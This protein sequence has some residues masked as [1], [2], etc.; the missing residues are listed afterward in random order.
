MTVQRPILPSVV[1]VRL[2]GQPKNR[3]SYVPTGRIWPSGDFS[4][5]Y[6]KIEPDSR[7]DYS[8]HLARVDRGEMAAPAGSAWSIGPWGFPVCDDSRIDSAGHSEALSVASET[9]LQEWI[10]RDGVAVPLDLTTPRNSH[11]LGNRPE[12]YGKQGITGHGRKMVKSAATLM[13]KMPGK[14]ITFATVT[15]PALP[16]QLRRELC[17]A[18]PELIRQLL[19][20][21]SRRLRRLGLIPAVCSVTEIQ[22]GRLEK[23]AEGYLHL[24][25]IWPNHWAKSGN[26]A[27]DV[28]EMRAWLSEFLQSRGLWVNEAWVNVDTQQVKKTAAGYL[29]KYM[30]KGSEELESFAEDC[31]WDCVPSQWWNLS[32][33]ARDLVKKYTREGC[34][35]GELLQAVIQHSLDF[36]ELA[37]F[38]VLCPAIVN[39]DGKDRIAGWFGVMTPEFRSELLAILGPKV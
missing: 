16:Q 25:L 13:Q 9:E 1:A 22:P 18:W 2:S 5:G 17:R 15:M 39:Y 38:H 32:K 34:P 35:V 3:A 33:P 12:K 30:S 28:S 36:Q 23:Y 37:Q 24:H 7:V 27:I 26:W 6:K 21:L 14:R 31:G 19:Q 20:W 29:S 4:L 11:N 10:A 8:S